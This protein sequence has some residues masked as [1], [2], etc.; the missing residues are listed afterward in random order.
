MKGSS[1]LAHNWCL[2]PS[3]G[4]HKCDLVETHLHRGQRNEKRNIKKQTFNPPTKV[5][6][7]WV[8]IPNRNFQHRYSLGLILAKVSCLNLT[9]SCRL[10]CCINTVNAYKKKLWRNV[11]CLYSEPAM[12]AKNMADVACS[13]LWELTNRVWLG[14]FGG[15]S[16]KTVQEKSRF[17]WKHAKIF[18]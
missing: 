8:Y 7:T 9:T 17:L 2:R 1:R 18:K 16:L 14:F 5:V 3:L 15:V 11:H 12:F 10:S 4:N 6:C 13:G